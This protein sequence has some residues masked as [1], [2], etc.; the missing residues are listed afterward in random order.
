M[1]IAASV[2]QGLLAFVFVG[3]GMTKLVGTRMQIENFDRYGYPQ[4]FRLVTEVAGA[5]GML[6]GIWAP[7]AAIAA[8]FWLAATMVG[9]FYTDLFRMG[10]L[11]RT[12]P[13]LVL[14]ALAL[15]VAALRIWELAD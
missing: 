4:W 10:S 7:E 2:I 5:A 3:S 1:T 9:A 14:L 6:I 15:T 11:V 8:G 13:P 12:L